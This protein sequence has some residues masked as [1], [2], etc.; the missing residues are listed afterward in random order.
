MKAKVDKLSPEEVFNTRK[1]VED[2]ISMLGQTYQQL[3]IAEQK[4]DE[5]KSVIQSL[6]TVDTSKELLVPLTNSLYVPGRLYAPESRVSFMVDIGTGYF[7]ER[8]PDE[9]LAYCER[10]LDIIHS[11]LNIMT[12]SLT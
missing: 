6:K 11:N 9:T 3:K 1:Q 12:K 10:K 5:S 4:Y 7:I 2:E 8:N